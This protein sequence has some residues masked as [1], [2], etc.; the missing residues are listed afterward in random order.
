[1]PPSNAMNRAKILSLVLPGIASVA[2]VLVTLLRPTGADVKDSEKAYELL[3][4]AVE[5]Q[6]IESLQTR[7]EVEELRAW[8]KIWT[9]Y[10]DENNQRSRQLSLMSRTRDA[11]RSPA[12]A[13]APTTDPIRGSSSVPPVPASGSRPSTVTPLPE[14]REVF[15]K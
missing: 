12:S 2:A 4:S 1:M 11:D 15:K 6:R 10:Q 7:R 13:P 14:G 5:Q 9:Q 8:L 3:R